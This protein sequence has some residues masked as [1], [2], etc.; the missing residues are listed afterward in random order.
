ME[1][2]AAV[3][4]RIAAPRTSQLLISRPRSGNAGFDRWCT[5]VRQLV[6]HKISRVCTWCVMVLSVVDPFTCVEKPGTE[7]CGAPR[8]IS[9]YN[10]FDM[11]VKRCLFLKLRP[12]YRS[13]FRAVFAL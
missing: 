11:T 7:C 10:I 5:C 3:P 13:R 4:F 1:L 2:A 6:H 9:T 8:V 12:L